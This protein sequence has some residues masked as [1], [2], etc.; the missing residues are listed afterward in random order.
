MKN[1]II[2]SEDIK[3]YNWINKEEIN[4]IVNKNLDTIMKGKAIDILVVDYNNPCLEFIVK[5]KVIKKIHTKVKIIV[6]IDIIE[7]SLIRLLYDNGIDYILIRP[8]DINT[9]MMIF[10]KIINGKINYNNFSLNLEKENMNDKILRLLNK[11]GMPANLKGY[12]YIKESLILCLKDNNYYLH[13]TSYLY[14]KLSKL[15]REKTSCIEKAMRNAIELSWC[16]GDIKEQDKIF[17]Y[18][19][20]RNKGRPTNGEFLAQLIN[21]ISLS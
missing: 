14:P 7:E 11:L 4:L 21:Y 16:R 20:D 19:I 17:G 10:N 18:T 9:L 12:K 8:L 2:N 5:I 15:F 6:A 3:D 1:I 13:T